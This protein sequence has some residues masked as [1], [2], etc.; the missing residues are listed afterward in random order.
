MK[1]DSKPVLR[2]ILGSRSPRRR[3]LLEQIVPAERIEVLPPR[4]ASE[5]DFDGLDS[6]AAIEQRLLEIACAKRD[7]VLAQIAAAAGRANAECA[8]VIAADTVMIAQESNGQAVVLGQ[9]P[10]D[11]TWSVVVRR[12]FEDYYFGKTVTAATAICAALANG[13]RAERIVLTM[14]TFDT[15][16]AEWLEW[17]LATGEPRGRAGGYAIQGAGGIFV[18]RVEGSLSNV[19]GLPL[20][21]L[22]ELLRELQL[23]SHLEVHGLANL[24]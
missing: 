7:D 15:Q 17:Y 4:D 2:W 3:E 9:P 11:A 6:Q 18:S 10:T 22:L 21:E 5:A 12:W 8:V 24:D 19:I 1:S 16:A 14:V 23:E 20:R 13:P